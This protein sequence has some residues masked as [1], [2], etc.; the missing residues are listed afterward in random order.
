VEAFIGSVIAIGLGSILLVV[1]FGLTMGSFDSG[2]Q[3][4][5][6]TIPDG[7]DW[8]YYF[9]ISL[10]SQGR[11]S[12]DFIE[13]EGR[14]VDFYILNERQFYT[15]SIYGRSTF[16]LR[17]TSWTGEFY[18]DIPSPGKYYMVFDHGPG[19]ESFTQTVRVN[20]R[21]VGLWAPL[22]A[23]GVASTVVGAALLVWGI[24]SRRRAVKLRGPPSP[25]SWVVFFEEAGR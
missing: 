8:Y 4:E 10:D 17:I 9:E 14:S 15:Y 23:A 11:I 25:A 16:L 24:T 21:V 19:H 20:Y 5:Q 18:L 1:G 22:L 7:R 2:V 3:T 12:G 13:V 6:F